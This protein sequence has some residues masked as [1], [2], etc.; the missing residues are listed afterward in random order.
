[1]CYGLTVGA[2]R[3]VFERQVGSL[4]GQVKDIFE[5]GELLLARAV[6]P[7]EGETRPRDRIRGGVAVRF[8]SCDLCV[9]PYTLRQVCTNG[10]IMVR[11]AQSVR[12]EITPESL[13]FE[14]IGELERAIVEC[15]SHA[16]TVQSITT[17]SASMLDSALIM[18]PYMQRLPQARAMI[19]EVL[20]R[21]ERDGER[22]RYG[23]MNAVTS[24]ARDT[25]D[26][27]RRWELEELG[28]MIAAGLPR[29]PRAMPPRR[30]LACAR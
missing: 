14:V 9:H 28:G 7:R 15:G 29:P 27:R 24:L 13:P 6:L 12:V 18:L 16:A 1:M 8:T 22:S 4:G 5:E 19:R 23:L 2:V 20:L 25:A 11:S 26:P 17:M 3:D 10:A 21:M 30:A